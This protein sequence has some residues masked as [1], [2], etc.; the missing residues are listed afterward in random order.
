M[1]HVTREKLES[2]IKIKLCANPW[3]LLKGHNVIRNIFGIAFD[4]YIYVVNLTEDYKFTQVLSTFTLMDK[5]HYVILYI[6][7][8]FMLRILCRKRSGRSQETGN[9]RNSCSHQTEAI[10]ND[11]NNYFYYHL[12]NNN[13]YYTII[14]LVYLYIGQ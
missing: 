5:L 7:V 9:S 3:L 14:H 11:I 4:S 10:N 8:E 2:V 13:K 1:L 6:V 12:N